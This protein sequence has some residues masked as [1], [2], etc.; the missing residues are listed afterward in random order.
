[1]PVKLND[2][3]GAPGNQPIIPAAIKVMVDNYR[4]TMPAGDA[5]SAWVSIS[6]VLELI[7][8]NNAN[9]IRIYYGRHGDDDADYPRKH[10]VI[11][12]ATRDAIHPENPSPENS[13]DLLNY[14]ANKGPVDSITLGR[15]SGLGDDVI[16]LCPPHCPLVTSLLS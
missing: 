7:A 14:D 15:F 1:M 11:L 3:L 16:P 6:E 4:S 10:N 2:D 13:N 8:Q 12:V 5:K 9:G